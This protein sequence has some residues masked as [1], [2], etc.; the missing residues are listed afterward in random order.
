MRENPETREHFKIVLQ[1]ESHLEQRR[2]SKIWQYY[3]KCVVR[4]ILNSGLLLGFTNSKEIQ[5]DFLQNLC[6]LID[7][8]SFEIRAPD[9]GFMKAVYIQAA[10]LSHDCMAN[11]C[12][13]I[14]DKYCMKIY[15]NRAI[16]MNEI[17]TN[18]YTNILLV[19]QTINFYYETDIISSGK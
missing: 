4:P 3:D 12:L 14:D 8:N 1:A 9:D 16:Q 17:I 7:V 18:C 5:E 2:N 10:L 11:T 6:S 15:A 13:A 19:S